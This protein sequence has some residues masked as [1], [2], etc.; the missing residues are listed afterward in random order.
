MASA[1]HR[2]IENQLD[3]AHLPFV[4]RST[5]GAGARSLVEGP[6]V[7]A[8]KQG[9]KIWVTNAKD[10]GQ[11]PR[12]QAELAKAAEGKGPGLQFLFP[13]IWMLNLSPNL[14]NVLA[15]VP[16]NDQKPL[17]Y[18]R[19]YHRIHIPL[20]ANLFEWLM[21]LSNRIILNQDKT[22]VLAQTPCNSSDAILDTFIGADFAIIQFRRIYADLLQEKK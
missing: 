5:I 15:F 1:L 6:Y 16:V 7:E 14:K 8:S 3:V 17:Y 12:K 9:I 2:A 21:N 22:V 4:H 20:I 19:V 11:T 18:L 10:E 13:G